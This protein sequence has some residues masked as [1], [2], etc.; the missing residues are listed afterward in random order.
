MCE[1]ISEASMAKFSDLTL[2]LCVYSV[3]LSVKDLDYKTLGVQLEPNKVIV[4][5]NSNFIHK[6]YEGFEN[7]IAQPKKITAHKKKLMTTPLFKERKKVGDG[8][9]FQSCL[10]FVILIDTK[11]Y[12]MRYFPKS[13]DIQVFGVIDEDYQS[14]KLAVQTFVD[15][16]KE[17]NGLSEFETVKIVKSNP[18]LLNF[19][20]HMISPS[21]LCVDISKL[22]SI[23]ASDLYQPPFKILFRSDP[24][25]SI[26]KLSIIFEFNGKKT[27]VIIWPS[28]KIN[29]MSATS[30][31]DALKIYNFLGDIFESEASNVL[32]IVPTPDPPQPKTPGRRGRK[33][34]INNYEL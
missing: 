17:S 16:L 10:D 6:A 30:Y 32:A 15:Y 13:G 24:I 4:A 14:G 33:K 25:E 21:N 20:Y 5:I 26:R 2:S 9:C 27:R 19:K 3:K 28:G 12:K 29:I 22:D 34:T 11:N 7:F 1:N 23:L 18:S 8:T 31:D